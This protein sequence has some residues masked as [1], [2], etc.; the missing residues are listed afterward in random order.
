MKFNIFSL[1]LT[2]NSWF[3]NSIYYYEGQILLAKTKEYTL[4]Y[5]PNKFQVV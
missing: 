1:N 4:L 2:G 3:F 5:I